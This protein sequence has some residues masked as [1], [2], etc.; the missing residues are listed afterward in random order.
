MSDIRALFQNLTP[1]TLAA[2]VADLDG[3]TGTVGMWRKLA[4]MAGATNCGKD[5]TDML[6]EARAERDST[7]AA[8]VARQS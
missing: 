3:K 7:V 5:F 6:R 8:T 4:E 2:I 1:T